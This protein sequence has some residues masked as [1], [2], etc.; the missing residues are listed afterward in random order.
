MST[1]VYL[2]SSI[3]LVGC[4][5]LFIISISMSDLK[6]FYSTALLAIAAFSSN[7]ENIPFP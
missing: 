6:S 5:I 7:T 3:R 2:S 4:S 1:N